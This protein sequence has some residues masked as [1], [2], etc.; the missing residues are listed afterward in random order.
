MNTTIRFLCSA[1]GEVPAETHLHGARDKV[2][3]KE[4]RWR[5]FSLEGGAAPSSVDAGG[6][7]CV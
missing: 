7:K 1:A 2:A 5:D 3:V 4:R 6:D